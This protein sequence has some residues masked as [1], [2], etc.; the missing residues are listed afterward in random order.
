[1]IFLRERP[2]H[3]FIGTVLVRPQKFGPPLVFASLLWHGRQKQ[4]TNKFYRSQRSPSKLGAIGIWRSR[5]AINN[6]TTMRAAGAPGRALRGAPPPWA[7]IDRCRRRRK[8]GVGGAPVAGQLAG[9]LCR[10]VIDRPRAY[11]QRM[12]KKGREGLRRCGQVTEC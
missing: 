10:R 8:Q 9:L 2:I 7:R 3:Q 5:G 12:D 4:I 6:W 1:M 11:W